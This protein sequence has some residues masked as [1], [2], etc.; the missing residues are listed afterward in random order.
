MANNTAKIWVRYH[1][2]RRSDYVPMIVRFG[3]KEVRHERVELPSVQ[4]MEVGCTV[5]RRRM[6]SS[7]NPELQPG[8]R[9]ATCRYSHR[10]TLITKLSDEQMIAAGYQSIDR[11]FCGDVIMRPDVGSDVQLPPEYGDAVI[12]LSGQ[13]IATLVCEGHAIGDRL[14]GP[15]RIV[16]N[17]GHPSLILRS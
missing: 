17:N 9:I 11:D 7:D 6:W 2:E 4:R 10:R 12:C 1:E 16:S 14:R 8:Q 5:T 15:F 13:A 3:S